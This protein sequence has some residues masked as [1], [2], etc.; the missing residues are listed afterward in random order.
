V[1]GVER[2]GDDLLVTAVSDGG[3]VSIRPSAYSTD[4]D[5]EQEEH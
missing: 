2:L 1:T 5:D 4:A 3:G